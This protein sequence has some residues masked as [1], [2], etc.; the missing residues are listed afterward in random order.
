MNACGR[1]CVGVSAARTQ[2]TADVPTYH[3]AGSV[4]PAA[5][6]LGYAQRVIA[7]GK[8]CVSCCLYRWF[9]PW[10]VVGIEEVVGWLTRRA[11]IRTIITHTRQSRLSNAP[12]PKQARWTARRPPPPPP[13]RTPPQPTTCCMWNKE[14]KARRRPQHPYHQQR[15][16]RRHRSWWP[17]LPRPAAPAGCRAE[18]A[19]PRTL[20]RR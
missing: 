6:L 4:G 12:Q 18:R 3:Q 17:P 2:L 19:T 1:R 16:R 8:W 14:E 20:R 10:L 7:W 11:H 15:R 5:A 9:G 13:L